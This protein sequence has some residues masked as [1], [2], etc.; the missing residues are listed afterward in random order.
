VKADY[1]KAFWNIVNWTDVAK[2]FESVRAN[3][4]SLLLG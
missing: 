2:R 3:S 1:V 4:S